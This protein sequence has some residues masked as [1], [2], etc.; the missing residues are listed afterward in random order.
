[1]LF[2][3]SY[4]SIGL[5]NLRI[6]YGVKERKLHQPRFVYQLYRST[7]LRCRYTLFGWVAWVMVPMLMILMFRCIIDVHSVMLRYMQVRSVGTTNHVLTL[8]LL[9][10]DFWLQ[11]SRQ[12]LNK[13]NTKNS[14]L[15]LGLSVLQF[16]PSLRRHSP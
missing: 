8:T 2:I 5:Q 12:R 11:A 1:M 6:S 14:Y 15:Q 16:D 4:P 13:R 3:E 7:T 10:P 9:I